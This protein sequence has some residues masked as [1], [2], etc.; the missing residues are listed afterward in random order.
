VPSAVLFG[1]SF[2]YL[3]AGESQFR[4]PWHWCDF[5]PRTMCGILDRLMCLLAFPYWTLGLDWKL[6][7]DCN[8]K[9]LSIYNRTGCIFV[10]VAS[11]CEL[12][13]LWWLYMW[14]KWAWGLVLFT[15]FY[16]DELCYGC[17]SYVREPVLYIYSHL[18]NNTGIGTTRFHIATTQISLLMVLFVWLQYSS[19]LCRRGFLT[20]LFF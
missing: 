9:R 18:Q 5:F 16:I 6:W 17:R 12:V 14:P 20:L 4:T 2:T 15:V 8:L 19:R 7:V 13:F 10:C 11:P 1:A 3:V